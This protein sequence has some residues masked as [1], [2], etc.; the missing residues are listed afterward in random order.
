MTTN[1]QNLPAGLAGRAAQASAA[2]QAPAPAPAPAQVAVPEPAASQPFTSLQP[3]DPLFNANPAPAPAPAPVNP[4][5]SHVS[6]NAP[7]E[8]APAATPPAAPAVPDALK[9]VALPTDKPA[10]AAP[11]ASVAHLA[12]VFAQDVNLAPAVGYLDSFCTDNGLDVARVFGKAAEEGDARFIDTGY[13]TE[14]LG[15]EAADKLVKVGSDVIAYINAYTDQ[16]VAEVHKAAGGEAQWEHAAKLYSEKADPMERQIVADLLN[17]G[18]RAK[19]AH[20]AKM[21]T[22]FAVSQGGAISHNAPALGLPGGQKG[23]TQAEHI[24]N[25]SKRGVT[26]EQYA[27]SVKMRR[28]GKSQ[29]L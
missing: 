7:A 29:G 28:L 16:S 14:K 27:E 15:K 21:V 8:P 23:L 13:L 3:Q 11:E 24:A 19:M 4:M 17:S 5:L 22:Q 26:P 18:D 25:I 10:E 20:A 12:G 2:P 6:Q 1:N 9:P